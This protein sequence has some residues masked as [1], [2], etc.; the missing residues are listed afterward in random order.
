[1]INYS[2]GS[3]ENAT[4]APTQCP[5]AAPCAMY[6]YVIFNVDKL[7]ILDMEIYFN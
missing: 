3:A 1:M 6:F 4:P 7:M 5:T 2:I